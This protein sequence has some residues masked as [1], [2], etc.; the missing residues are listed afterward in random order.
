MLSYIGA[1]TTLIVT[2]AVILYCDKKITES[3]KSIVESRKSI[4]ESRKSIAES[5]KSIVESRKKTVESRKSITESRKSITESR[6]KIIAY[7]RDT[8]RIL[9]EKLTASEVKNAA[10]TKKLMRELGEIDVA[11]ADIHSTPSSGSP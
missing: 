8:I 10:L 6:K 11:D 1:G 3:I 2:S 4:V 9:S 7:Q 5:R